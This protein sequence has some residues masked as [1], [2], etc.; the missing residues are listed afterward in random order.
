MSQKDK[1]PTDYSKVVNIEDLPNFNDIPLEG[2]CFLSNAFFCMMNKLVKTG[3]K[4]SLYESDLYKPS[5]QTIFTDDYP[6][7]KKFY[8]QKK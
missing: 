6:N 5:K 7:F 1:E 8:E 2:S 3:S 4:R